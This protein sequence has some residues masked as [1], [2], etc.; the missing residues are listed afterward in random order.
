V[1]ALRTPVRC[2]FFALCGTTMTHTEEGKRVG[3]AGR[4]IIVCNACAP[5]LQRAAR[6]TAQVARTG[7][8]AYAQRALPGFAPLIGQLQAAFTQPG[9]GERR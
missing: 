2:T 8:A 5:K 3:V 4:G 6:V 9:E 1:T 7:L